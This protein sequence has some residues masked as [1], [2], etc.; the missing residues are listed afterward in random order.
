MQG[1]LRFLNPYNP[2]YDAVSMS[3]AVSS[4]IQFELL[5]DFIIAGKMI[6]MK[7]S[8]VDVKTYFQTE[9]K[10]KDLDVKVSALGQP[11]TQLVNSQLLAGL[12]LKVHKSYKSEFSQTRLFVYD[13]FLMIEASPKLKNR[14]CE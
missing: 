14:I 6:D 10:L 2:L 5:H 11:F 9:V 8:V 3:V 13:S 4:K 12:G 7:I 1:R